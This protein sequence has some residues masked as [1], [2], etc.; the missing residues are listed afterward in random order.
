MA[1]QFATKITHARFIYSPF[2]AETMSSLGGVL[3]GSMYA[4]IAKGQNVTDQP[5]TQLKPKYAAAK[6]RKGRA[7]IRDWMFQL[8]TLN[9]MN[10]L[11]AS[12]NRAVIGFSHPLAAIHAHFQNMRQRQFGVSPN[13]EGVIVAAVSEAARNGGIVSVRQVA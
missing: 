10:V 12:E 6:I 1:R 2:S 4:R 3:R 9:Y 11:S 5:A 8:L 13:D 7:G